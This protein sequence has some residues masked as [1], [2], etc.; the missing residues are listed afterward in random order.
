MYILIA[1]DLKKKKKKKKKKKNLTG[2]VLVCF[3]NYYYGYVSELMTWYYLN[4]LF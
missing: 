4:L 2:R 1:L 3:G